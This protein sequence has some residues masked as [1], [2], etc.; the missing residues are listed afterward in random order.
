MATINSILNQS[1]PLA[2]TT[3]TIDP[4]ALG[5]SY[6]QFN[7]NTTGEFRIGVDDDDGDAFVIAQGST[8]GTNNA[9]RIS[10]T[11]EQT[12]PLQ[13]AFLAS[14]NAESNVTGNGT[15]HDIGSVTA[16]TEIVDRTGD[17]NPGNGAGT[18]AT[19]TAPITGYYMICCWLEYAAG[20]S[21]GQQWSV[22]IRTS[23]RSTIT[24]LL[25]LANQL[26]NFGGINNRLAPSSNIISDMDAADTSF[27]RTNG[28]LGSSA[29]D[30]VF[31]GVFSGFLLQ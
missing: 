6:I 8:L 13:P 17:F 19:F 31:R 24:V 21:G 27:I 15:P 25:P 29:T 9:F 23:N 26:T 18:A 5:D 10:A 14:I 12:L 7:I 11:G 30:D 1:N 22:T 2:S 28:L 3:I 4:G 20:A 16:T